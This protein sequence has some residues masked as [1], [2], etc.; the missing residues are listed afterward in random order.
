MNKLPIAKIFSKTK[1]P[2]TDIT[3]YDDLFSRCQNIE[4]EDFALAHSTNEEPKREFST[5]VK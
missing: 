3:A 1:K 2:P 5:A 4:Q